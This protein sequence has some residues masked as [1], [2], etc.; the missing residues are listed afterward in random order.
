[1]SRPEGLGLKLDFET[2]MQ[3]TWR[4]ASVGGM[5]V[6]ITNSSAYYSLVTIG[7]SLANVTASVNLH[8]HQLQVTVPGGTGPGVNRD[9]L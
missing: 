1:M 3:C 7:L 4:V 5:R 6:C 8:G 9:Y 2:L